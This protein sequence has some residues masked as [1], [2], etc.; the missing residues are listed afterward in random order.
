MRS[1]LPIFID[2]PEWRAAFDSAQDEAWATRQRLLDL[3][4]AGNALVFLSH[5]PFPG[6]GYIT[7]EKG[8]RRWRPIPLRPRSATQCHD[9]I[10]Y[11]TELSNLEEEL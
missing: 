4:E 10:C 7:R 8:T 9:G 11:P 6:L 1:P 2:H 3:A 5:F